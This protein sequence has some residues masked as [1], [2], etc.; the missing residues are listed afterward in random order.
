MS[1]KMSGQNDKN[2]PENSEDKPDKEQA[3]SSNAAPEARNGELSENGSGTTVDLDAFLTELSARLMTVGSVPIPQPVE[4][5]VQTAERTQIIVFGLGGTRYG[6]EMRYVNE[7][8]H[9]PRLTDVPGLPHW[10]M[11]VSNLH[12]DILSVVDLTRFLALESNTDLP[13]TNLVVAHAAEQRVGLMVHSVELIYTFPSDLILSPPF[14]IDTNVVPYLR[15][16][17]E[18]ENDFIRLLDCERLLLG[19]EM[20]QFA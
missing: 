9:E 19:S 8:V 2:E 3:A 4:E 15:G 6:V 7:I 12:G 11:G 1:I 18:R 5:A 13:P 14:K 17:V 10:V 20:Q 16:A